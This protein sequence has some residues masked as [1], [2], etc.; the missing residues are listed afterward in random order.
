MSTFLSRGRG[1]AV[2]Q[3]SSFNARGQKGEWG[4]MPARKAAALY[5]QERLIILRR[6]L[7]LFRD[8]RNSRGREN[9]YCF[10]ICKV[11]VDKSSLL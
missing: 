7:F 3:M 5:P 1:V 9:T 4:K 2:C 10:Y 8:E 11:F 6:W